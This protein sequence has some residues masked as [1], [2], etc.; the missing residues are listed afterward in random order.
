MAG[1]NTYESSHLHNDNTPA[2]A[3]YQRNHGGERLITPTSR[4]E[5]PDTF[6][7]HLSSGVEKY[8][9]RFNVSMELIMLVEIREALWRGDAR[10]RE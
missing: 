2:T 6:K 3:L 4:G 10:D 5:A 1:W 7:A 9:A 8:V